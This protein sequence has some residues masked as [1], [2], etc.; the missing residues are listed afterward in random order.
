[1][2]QLIALP[3]GGVA[4]VLV[5]WLWILATP[6]MENSFYLIP[7]GAA[8][9]SLLPLHELLH[10]L[11]HPDFGMSRKTLLAVWPS[12]LVCYAH[13]DGPR[14]R[15]RLLTGLALPFL[16]ITVIPLVISILSGHASLFIAF[17]S[18]LNAFGAGGDL[19]GILLLLWQVPRHARVFNQG[20]RT[21][22]SRTIQ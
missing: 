15:E 2:M 22:W 19:F 3:I 18:C 21:Y 7:L 8:L 11:A 10:A 5:G 6:V 12:R 13:Y 4:F 9:F 1:M 20:W 16:V 14:S 17:L